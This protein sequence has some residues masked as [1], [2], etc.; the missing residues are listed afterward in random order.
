MPYTFPSPAISKGSRQNMRLPP[1]CTSPCLRRNSSASALA[2]PRA[3]SG[4]KPSFPLVGRKT[5]INSSRCHRTLSRVPAPNAAVPEGSPPKTSVQGGGVASGC[6]RLH[7]STHPWIRLTSE[8]ALPHDWPNAFQSAVAWPVTERHSPDHSDS[9][10]SGTGQNSV[11]GAVKPRARASGPRRTTAKRARPEWP[12]LR[13]SSTTWSSETRRLSRRSLL[14]SSSSPETKPR[15]SSSSWAHGRLPTAGYCLAKMIRCGD[16]VGPARSESR[17]PGRRSYPE[18]LALW[19]SSR[20]V[21][22]PAPGGRA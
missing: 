12:V 8:L 5:S 20:A 6:R 10:R 22:N 3:V 18:W 16:G 13:W 15:N 4:E 19:A 17:D 7:A 11:W 2:N 1:T 9:G 14:R 21:A